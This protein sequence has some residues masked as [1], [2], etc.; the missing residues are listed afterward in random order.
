MK[1]FL[2]QLFVSD[3]ISHIEELARTG[4]GYALSG[5]GKTSFYAAL[6]ACLFK[7][8]KKNFVVIL[9]DELSAETYFQDIKTFSNDVENVKFLPLP[10]LSLQKEESVS[11]VMF[12]RVNVLTEIADGGQAVIIVAQPISLLKKIPLLSDFRK[13][14]IHISVGKSIR[15]D[16]VISRLLDYGYE[17]TDVVEEPGEFARRGSIVDLFTLDLR[18]PARI[19]FA[20]NTIR[21]IR[22]FEPSK[23]ISFEKI[24]DLAVLPLDERFVG[25]DVNELTAQIKEK[26][27][28]LAEPERFL[29]SQL[30]GEMRRRGYYSDVD[31]EKLSADAAILRETGYP[32]DAKGKFFYF[33]ILP[34]A[35]RFNLT[36]RFLWSLVPREKIAIFSDNPSQK[37]RLK[38]TL[39]EKGIKASGIKFFQGYV[40][41]GFSFPQTG[42]TVLSNDELFGRYKTRKSLDRRYAETISIGSYSDIREGDYVVHYNEGIGVFRGMERLTTGGTTE[43]FAVIEYE[44][45]DRLY[46]PVDQIIL[47]HKYVGTDNPKLS[48]LGGK[49]WIRIREKVRESVRDIASDL[50]QLYIARKKEQ[51]FAFLPEEEFQRAFDNSFI[52]AETDDQRR[53]I[54]EVK[55][56]MDAKNIMDR[57]IC[58]DS[59]YGKTE[60]ALRASCKAVISGKQV[61]VLAPTTVLALQHVLTFKERFADFPV[62][63]EML[64]RMLTPSEQRR[65]LEDVKE[66]RVDIVIGTHR[67]LRGD[68]IFKNLGLLI[69]DEEQRFGVVQKEKMK[70]QFKKIDVLTLTATPIPRTLY[71]ALSGVLD[72]S[73]IET[74]PYG[75]L[76]V[77]TYV[78][79]YNAT[80]IKEAVLREMERKGQVFYLHN[81]IYDIERVKERLISILPFAPR[82]EVAH[83][84]MDPTKL[85]S[86]M[87]R[88]SAG[89]IDILVAT[90]IVEN[91]ID[92]PR[93][94]TLIV[95]NAHTFGLADLYQLRGRVGRYKRRAYAYFLY[96]DNSALSDVAKERLSAIQQLSRPGSGYKV[97][98]KD[99]E[100]RGAGNILG[101]QQHG[102]IEQVG[103]ELYCRF[104]REVTGETEREQR[105]KV[106]KKTAVVIPDEYIKSS[107]MRFALYRRIAEITKPADVDVLLSEMTDRFGSPPETLINALKKSV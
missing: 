9:P 69:I 48:T 43:E 102:F 95:D 5:G 35:E 40:S 67:L 49:G 72:V 78:G 104:W 63:V 19:E 73:V 16:F 54:E 41:S 23:Q 68:A 61:V 97:A 29:D 20:G 79:K 11:P 75:R 86:V 81:R 22:K 38:E 10:E 65:V 31:F 52:Y 7:R 28:F 34:V 87:D 26:A 24:K 85:A 62:R 53:A 100:I 14:S 15:R 33:K 93:A 39:K 4:A 103:F 96:P 106:P 50:Y 44:K 60:V 1:D 74:P 12:E 101:R 25:D 21:S 55:K 98:L 36:E 90:S 77:I 13:S 37:T 76:S 92:I 6:I 57:I 45:G 32:E 58:G 8:I 3:K 51:G 71:M 18:F 30:W 46:V 91:G 99:L 56:D 105:Q 66:G 17:E 2:E 47:L 84:R 59:G 64:S 80:L 70:R 89:A 82:I 83:G 107:A 42:I 94:N 27:V 88:F